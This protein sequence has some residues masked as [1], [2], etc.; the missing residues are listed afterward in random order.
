MIENRSPLLI[1]EASIE[2]WPDINSLVLTLGFSIPQAKVKPADGSA[3]I[4]KTFLPYS[5]AATAIQ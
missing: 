5:L 2:N 4:T 1:I 3:S